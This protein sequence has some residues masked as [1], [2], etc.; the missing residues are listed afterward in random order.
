MRANK[1]PNSITKARRQSVLK[2]LQTLNSTL[3]LC[4]GELKIRN[5]DTTYPFRVASD[6]FYLTG[7]EEA[8]AFLFLD[9]NSDCPEKLFVVER[10]S[11]VEQWEGSIFGPER[12]ATTFGFESCFSNEKFKDHVAGSKNTITNWSSALQ[13]AEFSHW[14]VTKTSLEAFR[15]VKDEFELREMK[16]SADMASFAHRQLMRATSAGVNECALHGLFVKSFMEK[17]GAAEAYTAIVAS[18]SNA[19]TL[20]YTFNDRILKE[21]QMLLVDAGC[22]SCYYASDITRSYPVSGAFTEEQGRVYEKLLSIQKEL[23]ASLRAGVFLKDIQS[24]SEK[25]ILELL[26]SEGV[27][28]SSSNLE[29]KEF[30]DYYP[31][32]F[33]HFIGLDVHDVGDRTNPL[34]ENSVITVEP[35]VYFSESDSRV[36]KSLRGLGLRIED[37]V[38]IK[39]GGCEVLTTVEKEVV[40]LEKLVGTQKDLIKK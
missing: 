2:H 14:Q 9:P 10:N 31:H 1:I 37:D 12:A 21:G 5:A 35:G 3:L 6:F 22:E 36:P 8:N 13:E 20:H 7:F 29:S 19:I 4:S 26:H 30:K 17:G 32:G 34:P 23:I 11:R 18:G 27:L 24:L 25:L 16:N 15:V 28:P 39:E 40:Q 33:G 38:V